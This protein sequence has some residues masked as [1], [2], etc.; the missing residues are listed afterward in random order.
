MN[1]SLALLIVASL[2]LAGCTELTANEDGETMNIEVN[3]DIAI[4]KINDFMTVDEDESFGITMMYE[5][6]P[7]ET[8]LEVEDDSEAVITIEM[9]EA[10]SP[11]GYHSSSIM[12]L[13]ENES[14]I[15][16][17]T[18]VTHIGTTMYVQMGYET[19]GDVCEGEDTPEETEMCEMM[20]GD[21]PAPQAYSMTTTTTHTEVIAAMAEETSDN[22]EDLNPLEMLEFF[23]FVE[24]S[25]TFTPVESVDGL[26]IFSVS[27]EGR[28]DERPS[29]EMALCMADTDG[30]G[31]VSL[32]EFTSIDETDEED[33]TAMQAA[34]DE[35][36]ANSDVELTV[37][38]LG[39]FIDSVD[40]HYLEDDDDSHDG[41]D[42]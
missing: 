27:M 7:R 26:Q 36:D 10:W 41:D 8:G 6:D 11:D 13:A 31:G 4:D 20:Y 12:G 34:F 15:K 38:E 24:C 40:E 18:S 14:S 2:L 37:D 25:G 33:M 17:V 1:K 9:T 16:F 35:A 42:H 21:M 19:V 23:S 22:S 5:M 29:A 39:A 32:E 28:D 30:S 3:E